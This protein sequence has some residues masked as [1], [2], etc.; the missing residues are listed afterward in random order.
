MRRFYCEGCHRCRGGPGV[1]K[2]RGTRPLVACTEKK[3][4][5]RAYQDAR[6]GGLIFADGPAKG[7]GGFSNRHARKE[8]KNKGGNATDP[9]SCGAVRLP[10]VSRSVSP[11]RGGEVVPVEE[12]RKKEGPAARRS[13]IAQVVE[14][15]KGEAFCQEQERRGRTLLVLRRAVS[16]PKK[17]RGAHPGHG[18]RLLGG[19]K[20][21][22][23]AGPYS[24]KKKEDGKRGCSRASI[25][26]SWRG[27]GNEK[28]FNV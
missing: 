8:K 2:D 11:V 21:W 26:S 6:L 27:N 22:R 20:L 5:G 18:G 17:G 14:K 4:R 12:K 3:K 1:E 9:A 19:I 24:L 10:A 25:L 7:R 23:G 28:C 13:V 16:G 15:K